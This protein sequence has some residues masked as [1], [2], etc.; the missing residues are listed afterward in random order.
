MYTTTTLSTNPNHIH[1][2]RENTVPAIIPRRTPYATQNDK[3]STVTISTPATAANTI[4]PAIIEAT[5]MPIKAISF[6]VVN[7]LGD[8]F[9]LYAQ[10]SS[11]RQM[12]APFLSDIEEIPT[13]ELSTVSLPN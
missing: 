2:R 7:N 3:K 6:A 13:A 9:R 5:I 4:C 10:D 1:R 12:I 8:I 11:V